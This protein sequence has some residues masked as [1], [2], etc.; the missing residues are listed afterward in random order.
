VTP[1]VAIL[2]GNAP[3]AV[4]GNRELLALVAREMLDSARQQQIHERTVRRT[5]RQL[6]GDTTKVQPV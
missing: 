1:T 5:L 6:A 2:F 4:S 3:I